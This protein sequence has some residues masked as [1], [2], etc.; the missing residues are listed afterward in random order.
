VDSLLSYF[1]L[2]SAYRSFVSYLFGSAFAYLLPQS[3]QTELIPILLPCVMNLLEIIIVPLVPALI[4]LRLGSGPV[5]LPHLTFPLDGL[6]SHLS[7]RT[8]DLF[9]VFAMF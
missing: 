9:S 7:L 8:V 4:L 3:L 5:L 1:S 6:D 2:Q